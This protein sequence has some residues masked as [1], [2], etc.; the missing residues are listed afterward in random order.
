MITDKR[1]AEI[2]AIPDDQIDTSD[3]LEATEAWFQAAWLTRLCVGNG[4]LRPKPLV[5]RLGWYACIAPLAFTHA[6]ICGRFGQDDA[7]EDRW[8]YH[9]RD[10]AMAALDAWNGAGEPTGWHRHPMSGRRRDVEA[11][12]EWIAP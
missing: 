9:G 5:E 7:Y 11:G 1:L 4:Y 8:C 2:V 10:A 3:I 12:T 6:I